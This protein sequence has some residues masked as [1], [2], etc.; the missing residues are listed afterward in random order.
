MGERLNQVMKRVNGFFIKGADR[1]FGIRYLANKFVSFMGEDYIAG[2][3]LREAIDCVCDYKDKGRYSTVDVLGEAA[4]SRNNMLRYRDAYHQLMDEINI[5]GLKNT[6]SV[7]LKPSAICFVKE[8][9]DGIEF[10]DSTLESRL[11]EMLTK[12]REF[13]VNVTL[14]MEDHRYI[15]QSLAAAQAM[16]DKGY[17]N[18]GIVLQSRLNR[19]AEDIHELF[20]PRKTYAVSKS[21]IRVR[22]CI[23]IYDEPAD[24]AT[25]SKAE[26]KNRL[27]KDIVALFETGVY[28]EIATHDH[29]VIDKVVNYVRTHNISEDEFE[30][31]FLKGVQ[32]AYDKE[33]ELKD[34][35][36]KVR[37][38]MPYEIKA[39]DGIP[40]MKRRIIN[41]PGMV[42]AAVDNTVRKGVSYVREKLGPVLEKDSN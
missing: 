6:A 9:A 11:E 28:V 27:Y 29:A 14:D 19:T 38:Y 16:W 2:H 39:G 12:A 40:Y 13:G 33:A 42:L 32:K 24:I 3:R 37:F 34:R 7:S 18:L 8:H 36:Y 23:G 17:D 31:Q 35:G 26:A 25:T 1:I 30:F 20:C 4:K 41:N 5:A 15:D 10:V 21:R 22:V